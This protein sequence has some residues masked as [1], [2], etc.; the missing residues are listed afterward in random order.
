MSRRWEALYASL[1]LGIENAIRQYDEEENLVYAQALEDV[2][3]S[4]QQLELKHIN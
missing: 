2:I 1:N 3:E 4:M